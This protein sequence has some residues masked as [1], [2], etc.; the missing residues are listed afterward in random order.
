VRVP[1]DNLNAHEARSDC[2]REPGSCLFVGVWPR[3]A[4][5]LGAI[6]NVR[7]RSVRV[8][9]RQHLVLCDVLVGVLA[10]LENDGGNRAHFTSV[11]G[12]VLAGDVLR[13]KPSGLAI[14]HA[15]EVGL[16]GLVVVK[17]AGCGASLV[18]R[19]EQH[20]LRQRRHFDLRATDNLQSAA[21]RHVSD[22]HFRLDLD[23]PRLDRLK[24]HRLSLFVT[25]LRVANE[26]STVVDFRVRSA[27][28]IRHGHLV[29]VDVLVLVTAVLRDNARNGHHSPGVHDVELVLVVASTEP[30]FVA[31]EHAG[32]VSVPRLVVAMRGSRG[33]RVVGRVHQDD[34]G[35]IRNPALNRRRRRALDHKQTSA[36]GN[37][38]VPHLD[39]DAHVPGL[40]GV[41]E[42]HRLR[43]VPH[44][45][46]HEQSPAVDVLEVSVG[47]ADFRH[48][49]L[50][51]SHHLVRVSSGLHDD[52][53]DGLRCASVDLHPLAHLVARGGPALN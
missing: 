17:H 8:C 32:V 45:V 41:R 33:A 52:A 34:R 43:G 23:V 50:E 11:D 42:Q 4:D 31:V 39:F 36:H 28:L 48:Q 14:E 16:T 27:K 44:R 21:H 26:C 30:A 13:R 19:V 10:S 29:E 6:S 20:R 18:R 37:V 3:V 5:E 12:E 9:A 51:H 35:G 7:K 25:V 40:H 53:G 1:G 47:V 15:R 22:P 46:A 24:E 49:H 38:L 2:L